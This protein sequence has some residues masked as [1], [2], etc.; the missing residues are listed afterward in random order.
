MFS[1]KSNDCFDT[2]HTYAGTIDFNLISNETH[3]YCILVPY[4]QISPAD[5]YSVRIYFPQSN[6][7][8]Y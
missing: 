2:N 3:V 5:T 1:C 6:F 8:F 7:Y 4:T